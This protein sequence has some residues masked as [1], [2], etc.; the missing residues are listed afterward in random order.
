MD[1]LDSFSGDGLVQSVR[2][3]VKDYMQKYDASHGWDHIQRVVGLSRHIY[4]QTEDKSGLDLRIIQ[5]SALLHDVGDRKYIKPDEDPTTMVLKVLE[6]FGAS[7]ELAETVQTICG[8]VSYSSEIKDP[9]RVTALIAKHPELAVVQ[10]ADRLDAIGAVGIGRVFTYSGARTARDMEDSLVHMDEKLLRLES[11]AKTAAGR[12]LARERTERLR[13]F[14][15]WWREEV[16]FAAPDDD[17][18]VFDN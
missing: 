2:A 1:A 18:V 8:G 13:I 16:A 5:L 10:D 12:A 3:Y 11:M 9:A 14:K 17:D 15:M 4:A 6:S 7:V